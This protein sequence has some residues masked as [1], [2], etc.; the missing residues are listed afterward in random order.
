V[1]QELKD[2]F[3]TMPADRKCHGQ[4]RG[5]WQMPDADGQLTCVPKVLRQVIDDWRKNAEKGI[6]NLDLMPTHKK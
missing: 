1:V 3:L 4:E 6:E 2:P 5:G